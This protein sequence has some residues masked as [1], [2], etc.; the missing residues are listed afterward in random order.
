MKGLRIYLTFIGICQSI[1]QR[2]GSEANDHL[3]TRGTSIND[4][5]IHGSHVSNHNNAGSYSP[6]Q[7]DVNKAFNQLDYEFFNAFFIREL[8]MSVPTSSPGKFH[9]EI[10]QS[11]YPAPAFRL[12]FEIDSQTL[13][14][15]G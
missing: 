6:S 3:R 1:G 8:Q 10:K 7:G 11:L 4:E 14:L 9:C 2:T 13:F 15:F 12:V 5:F